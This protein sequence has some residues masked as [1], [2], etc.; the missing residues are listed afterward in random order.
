MPEKIEK[1]YFFIKNNEDK[2]FDQF[3]QKYKKNVFLT[4]VSQST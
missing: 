4:G 1:Y 2:F 3:E